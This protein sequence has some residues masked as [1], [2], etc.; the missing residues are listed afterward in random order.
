MGHPLYACLIFSILYISIFHI[1]NRDLL[2][3][4]I[5][6]SL[7]LNII[8]DIFSENFVL[9]IC[10]RKISNDYKLSVDHINLVNISWF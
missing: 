8:N 6:T 7:F 4:I 2:T 1:M 3:P 10:D 5:L 9:I